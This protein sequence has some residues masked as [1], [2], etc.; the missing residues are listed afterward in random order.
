[1][2]GWKEIFDGPCFVC[3]AERERWLTSGDYPSYITRDYYVR[4]S[5][6]LLIAHLHFEHGLW[7]NYKCLPCC[8]VKGDSWD[9]DLHHLTRHHTPEEFKKLIVLLAM[10][11]TRYGR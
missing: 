11:E 3:G 1:M 9:E 7:P 8:G 2:T 6:D 10:S 5:G 4:H